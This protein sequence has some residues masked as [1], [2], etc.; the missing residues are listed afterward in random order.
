MTT[1]D[2]KLA[3][4]DLASRFETAFDRGDVVAHLATWTDNPHL[5]SNM[6]NYIG[7]PAYREWLDSFMAQT[8][9]AGG[10]RHLI[11]NGEI[12]VSGDEASA[13]FYLTVINQKS[14]LIMGTATFDDR[15]V[16]QADGWRFKQRTLAV[17]ANLNI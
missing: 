14:G 1:T 8:R 4:A 6:G 13:T 17:D 5:E 9:A 7:M 11:T 10:T 12:T 2:D 3:I 15:L 16:R